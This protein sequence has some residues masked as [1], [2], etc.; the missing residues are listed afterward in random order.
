LDATGIIFVEILAAIL[1]MT[2]MGAIGK[3]I[4]KAKDAGN[5]G[6]ALGFF[7]GPIG[8]LIVAIAFDNRPLCPACKSHV[9]SR[10]T[11]CPHCRS[12]LKSS[13]GENRP[14]LEPWPDADPLN[15]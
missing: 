9:D 11:I 2:V 14:Y 5:I 10:A 12:V 4:G 3:V 8:L 1:A 7:L 15:E 13:D 6:F